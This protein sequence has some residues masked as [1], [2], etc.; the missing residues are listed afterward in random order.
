MSEKYDPVDT[1]QKE[2][3]RF[4]ET[5]QYD[6]LSVTNFYMQARVVLNYVEEL[7]NELWYYANQLEPI[8]TR[9]TKKLLNRWNDLS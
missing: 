1:L 6:P 3:D 4:F 2:V 9:K 7:E 8:D 5:N